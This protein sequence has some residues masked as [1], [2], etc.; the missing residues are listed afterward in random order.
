MAR[1]KNRVSNEIN[2]SS[3]ADIAFLL[4]IFFLV[5]TTIEVDKG[6]LHKLPP[7]T[8]EEPPK[9]ESKDRNTLVV[10]INARDQLLVD[11]KLSTVDELRETTKNF[12]ENPLNKPDLAESPQKA[13]VSLQNDRGTSYGLYIEVQNELK[14]AYRELRDEYVRRNFASENL[15]SFEDL[16]SRR[17]QARQA[18][19]PNLMDYYDSQID[20]VT[21]AYPLRLSEAEPKDV[22]GAE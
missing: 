18:N 4:L 19:K 13:I 11:D 1:S 17:E 9:A 5:T 7:W 20:K 3:M 12:I 22:G 21:D 2:A 6:I 15:E 8:E 16:K 10:L 14:A